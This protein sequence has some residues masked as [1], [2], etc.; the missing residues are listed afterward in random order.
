VSVLLICFSQLGERELIT[1]SL[2]F[3]AVRKPS[4]DLIWLAPANLTLRILE[5]HELN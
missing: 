3:I 1:V 2:I 4:L 5:R